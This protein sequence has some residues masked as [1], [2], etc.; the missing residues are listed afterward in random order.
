MVE[1]EE[2]HKEEDDKEKATKCQACVGLLALIMAIVKVAIGASVSKF[3]IKI[4]DIISML[5]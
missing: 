2:D 4:I 5:K 1:K 3:L